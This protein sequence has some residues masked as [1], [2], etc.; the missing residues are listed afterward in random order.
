MKKALT[1][2][3]ACALGA[4]GADS[5]TEAPPA[6]PTAEVSA[7]PTAE[8]SAAPAPPPAPKSLY[9]RLN[10]NVGI[11]KFV[12]DALAGIKAD[13]RVAKY[14]P[15][16]AKKLAALHDDLVSQIGGG[17]GGPASTRADPRL[18]VAAMKIKPKDFDFIIEDITKAAGS[19]GDA[20]AKEILAALSSMKDSLVAGAKK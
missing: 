11:A 9:D 14:L 1:V 19:V 3:V 12:D 17:S 7:A 20:E 10:G 16:D 18:A 15:K 4:C 2:L 5:K 13:K 8:A 6:T